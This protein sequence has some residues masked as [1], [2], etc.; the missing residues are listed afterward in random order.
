MEYRTIPD[1][2]ARC[3]NV[4]NGGVNESP[5][6]VGA[7]ARLFGLPRIQPGKKS[8]EAPLRLTTD[9]SHLPKHS[10]QSIGGAIEKGF[11]CL[12]THPVFI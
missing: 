7:R 12:A 10:H 9:E 11:L 8:P 1:F 3:K 2:V 6:I 4:S 5:L